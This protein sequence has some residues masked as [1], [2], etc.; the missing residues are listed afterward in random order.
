ME[1]IGI[2]QRG[3]TLAAIKGTGFRA[4]VFSYEPPM[5]WP[6]NTPAIIVPDDVIGF[7]R[8]RVVVRDHGVALEPWGDEPWPLAE[9]LAE[10]A[11]LLMVLMTCF[12]GD[13]AP[14]N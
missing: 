9:E 11:E 2:Q 12:P 3:G 5:R 10:Y 1:I 6:D 8:G 14:P 4:I 7:I 13:K